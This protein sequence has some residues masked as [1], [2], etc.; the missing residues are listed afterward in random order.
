MGEVEEREGGMRGDEVINNILLK[1]CRDDDGDGECS[2]D[3]FHTS[4]FTSCRHSNR[5]KGP[6]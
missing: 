3:S 6:R 1:S 5:K 2:F 4:Q